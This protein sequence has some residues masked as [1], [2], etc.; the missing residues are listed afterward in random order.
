MK[1]KRLQYDLILPVGQACGCSLTLRRANLQL[2]SFPGDWTGPVWGNAEHPPLEHDL[3]NRIDTL[4]EPPTDFFAPEAFVQHKA[5]SNTG[6]QVYVN[7]RTQYVFN[8]DF[9]IG[10]DFADELPKVVARYR[11]RRNRLFEAIRASHR[12]L[13]VRIDIPGGK[14]PATLDD[15]RYARE[16]L[17]RAFPA[18][19][20]DLALL[21][22]EEGRPFA[23][24]TFD[25]VDPGLFR[26]AFDFY[27][28]RH[29]LPNQPDLARTAS[30]LQEHFAV[31]DYRTPEER[32]QF[33]AREAAKKAERH[34]LK[35]ARTINLLKG[36]WYARFN[37]IADFL[38][39]RH[40]Q[41][42]DQFVILGFNCETAFR[43]YHRWGFLDSSLFAWANTR[44][45][46]C[47]TE[48]IR[49]LDCLGCEGFEFHALS[50]MWKCRASGIYFHGKMRAKA[51]TPDPS[52]EELAADRD[53]LATRLAHLKEKFIRYATNEKSTL[54][55]YRLREEDVS[56]GLADK[57][58][59]LEGALAS[60]G[61]TNFK[62]LVVTTR[63]TLHLMP[64][65][66]NRIFRA[67]ARFNPPTDVTTPRKGDTA[68]WNRIYSEFAPT[69]IL[70]KKH[71]FKFEDV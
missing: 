11:K 35:R 16:R 65:S 30:A 60:L 20:F 55:V 18:V 1:P 48:A 6:K 31:I 27:D 14:F 67:V 66:S 10:R 57:I 22:Y 54:F 71:T 69:T 24:R 43:F 70:P 26:L 5:I 47:L 17:S 63:K 21:S 56:S 50:R 39:R 62:L 59:A 45:L 40:R 68:G 49:N 37:P 42:F 4:L 38:A 44:D 12:V 23:E 32:A 64:P 9:T 8:H 15:C 58:S 61:A 33:A 2:L 46:V 25:E 29:A 34:R 3:R 41:T 36:L 7:E 51:G 13:V 52:A 53:D 19:A 28:H